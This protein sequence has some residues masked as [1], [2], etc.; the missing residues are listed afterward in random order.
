ME[1]GGE[2]GTNSILLLEKL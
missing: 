1:E 2:E